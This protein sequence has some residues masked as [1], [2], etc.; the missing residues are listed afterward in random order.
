MISKSIIHKKLDDAIVKCTLKDKLQK[1]ITNRENY[2]VE[3]VDT[4]HMELDGVELPNVSERMIRATKGIVVDKY[5]YKYGALEM[6]QNNQQEK[7][8][9]TPYEFGSCNNYSVNDFKLVNGQIYDTDY[10]KGRK[11]DSPSIDDF[12]ND[13]KEHL[14]SA[15]EK[16]PPLTQ[17]TTFYRYGFFPKGMK[18]GDTGK[19]K[20]YTSTTYQ[21]ET[22]EKFKEGY[23]G[24]EQDRYKI[25]IRAPKGTKGVLL[26]QQFEAITEHEFLLG[27]NQKYIILNVND[28]THEVEIGLY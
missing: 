18:I 23:Y 6:R 2:L 3:D 5:G 10:Y 17:D 13:R 15:I 27:R 4:E 7:V 20:G 21:E 25:V 26:N 8:D 22:A 19:F 1:F 28:E 16:S 24:G 11:K 14:D 9:Y 12:I